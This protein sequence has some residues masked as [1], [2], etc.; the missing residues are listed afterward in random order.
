MKVN[1]MLLVL[2]LGVACAPD[3]TKVDDLMREAVNDRV[4]PGG[5]VTVAN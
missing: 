4:F 1:I 3:W 2:V 5:S